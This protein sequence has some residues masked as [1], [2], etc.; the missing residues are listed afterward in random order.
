[1][2]FVDLRWQRRATCRS[3]NP[4]LF[5]GPDLELA[6]DR[7]TREAKAKAI[8]AG[9]PVRH[10]CLEYRLSSEHQGDGGIWAGLDEYERKRIRRNMLRSRREKAA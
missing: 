10:R 1:M 4:A 3:E 8:C 9:C 6:Q 2:S 7:L 5:F